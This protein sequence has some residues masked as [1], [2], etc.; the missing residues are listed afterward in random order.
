MWIFEP[1]RP[2]VTSRTCNTQGQGPSL[3]RP[4]WTTGPP[5]GGPRRTLWTH[6]AAVAPGKS[7][8]CMVGRVLPRWS[9]KGGFESEHWR[10]GA[11]KADRCQKVQK[12][13][14]G[15][16]HAYHVGLSCPRE[17]YP[18]ATVPKLSRVDWAPR[19]ASKSLTERP[20]TLS[21]RTFIVPVRGLWR[22][23]TKSFTRRWR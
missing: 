14:N 8:S 3:I 1:E 2:S 6:T 18:G 7:R 20:S 21:L 16:A 22:L 9:R 15:S 23:T 13:R 19:K 11:R 4:A 12:E 17:T 5:S 10:K